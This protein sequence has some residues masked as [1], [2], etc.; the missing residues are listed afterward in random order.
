MRA[1]RSAVDLSCL[2]NFAPTALVEQLMFQR[3]P[4]VHGRCAVT[5]VPRTCTV[6]SQKYTEVRYR[7]DPHGTGPAI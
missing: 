6:R 2:A 3:R 5:A 1:S 7:L 4:K